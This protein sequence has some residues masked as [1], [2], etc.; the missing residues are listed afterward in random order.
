MSC[1]LPDTAAAWSAVTRASLRAVYGARPD[2][3]IDRALSYL[4]ASTAFDVTLAQ[5]TQPFRGGLLP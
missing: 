2:P 3:E 5:G 4:K 1:I